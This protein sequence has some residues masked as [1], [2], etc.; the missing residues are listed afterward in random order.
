MGDYGPMGCDARFCG[1]L[2][3]GLE[4]SFAIIELRV[5]RVI[6]KAVWMLAVGSGALRG[7]SLAFLVRAGKE[8]HQYGQFGKGYGGRLVCYLWVW[9]CIHVTRF[10]RETWDLAFRCISQRNEKPSRLNARMVLRQQLSASTEPTPW[11]PLGILQVH[12]GQAQRKA[13]LGRAPGFSV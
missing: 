7:V 8:I 9:V 2:C 3:Q 10:T 1:G 5:V 11:L 4:T 12:H 13:P 6:G